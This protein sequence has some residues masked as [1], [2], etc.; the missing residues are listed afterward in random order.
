MG[1]TNIGLNTAGKAVFWILAVL[2]VIG[3]AGAIA[4]F[5]AKEEGITYYI[6]Y[7]GEKFYGNTEGK[8]LNIEGGKEYRFEVKSIT[9]GAVNYGVSVTSNPANN[10][11]FTVDGKLHI[12][13]GSDASANDYTSV[14]NVQKEETGFVLALPKDYGL[15]DIIQTKYSGQDIALGTFADK[16]YF[17]L[18]VTVEESSVSFWFGVK[19]SASGI[20]VDPPSIVF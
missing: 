19:V 16:E 9:G 20:A 5:V 11:E 4:Y 1:K 14:F 12:W 15:K 18:T 7:G 10:F 6:E 8:R 2:L 13:N 3:I 17:L